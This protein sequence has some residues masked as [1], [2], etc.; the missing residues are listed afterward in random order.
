MVC[1]GYVVVAT[2]QLVAVSIACLCVMDVFGVAAIV[3]L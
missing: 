2:C 1:C 3:L